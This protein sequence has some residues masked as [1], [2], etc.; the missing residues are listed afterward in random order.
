MTAVDAHL[1]P[2]ADG[3]GDRPEWVVVC[4]WDALIPDR[5][6]CALVG[7][8][9]VAVFRCSFRSELFAIDNVD[10][11]TGASVL[12]RGLVGATVDGTTF[13]SSPLR[14]QRFALDT[15][16][17]LDDP[18]LALRTWPTAV[19]DGVVMVATAASTEGSPRGI[20]HGQ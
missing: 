12:S 6:V 15:G 18:E 1:D 7:G 10:P 11:F 4:P 5:G 3:T 2:C 20:T 9:A 14:K 16:R 17:C 8:A 19:V 13:V